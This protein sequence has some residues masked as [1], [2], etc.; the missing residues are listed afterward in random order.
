MLVPYSTSHIPVARLALSIAA[1]SAMTISLLLAC[2]TFAGA[3][4]PDV[5]A[6]V[7]GP[8]AESAAAPPAEAAASSAAAEPVVPAPAEPESAATGTASKDLPTAAPA[9]GPSSSSPVPPP[10]GAGAAGAGAA[11]TAARTQL[12]QAVRRPDPAARVPDVR[13]ADPAAPS[14]RSGSEQAVRT[15][16]R[17]AQTAAQTVAS[18]TKPSDLPV[19]RAL[20]PLDGVLSPARDTLHFASDTVRHSSRALLTPSGVASLLPSIG[21]LAGIGGAFS[22]ALPGA[23]ETLPAGASPSPRVEDAILESLRMQHLAEFG[24]IEPSPRFVLPSALGNPA[25]GALARSP[26]PPANAIGVSP[27]GAGERP[28]GLAPLDGNDPMPSPGAPEGAV[29]GLGGSS[30]VPIVALLALAA[31]AI[32]RRLGEG[33]DFRAPIPFVCALER[34]G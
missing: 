2:A 4:T 21:P 27:G 33:P 30:L 28:E 12:K 10:P 18:G 22:P 25:L 3:A 9:S 23:P 32:F 20:A 24:G 14:I 7:S 6:V 16:D 8:A 1:A 29:S 19:D 34:P 31:P 15:V 13:A 26:A 17:A 11:V 5:A